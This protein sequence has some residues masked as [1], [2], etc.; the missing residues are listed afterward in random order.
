MQPPSW[1]PWPGSVKA[2]DILNDQGSDS[3]SSDD[4]LFA[5]ASN[6]AQPSDPIFPSSYLQPQN[7]R[8]QSLS[9]GPSSSGAVSSFHPGTSSFLSSSSSS[10]GDELFG[11]SSHTVSISRPSRPRTIQGTRSS[12]I[13]GHKLGEGAY[14]VVREGIDEQSLRIVAVKV[15]DLRRLR[16]LRGGIEA[17][18]REVAVQQRLKKHPNLVELID[19][20]RMPAKSRMYIILEMA[21]GGTVQQLADS[22]PDHCLPE[23]QV[24]NF[25]AQTLKGLQ[26]MHGKGVVHRDI[27]PSNLMLT[28]QG[29]LMISDFGVAE[30]LNEYNDDDN[31]TR[32]SGSPAFQAPEIAIGAPGYSGMK[33]DVW[34]L[35][36]TVYFL[37]T[38]TIPFEAD[39]LL[40]LFELIGKGEYKEPEGFS[41]ACMDC[42]SRMMTVDWGKRASVDELLKHPWI[43]KGTA[44]LSSQQREERGWVHIPKKD[45]GILQIVTDMYKEDEAIPPPDATSPASSAAPAT[46]AAQSTCTVQ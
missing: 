21:N 4:S 25:T 6:S 33:V 28:A 9:V 42:I 2:P 18:E 22:V 35:G 30:F 24:A 16:K 11:V 38:G 36:V 3:D 15:L 8:G 20:V 29:D 27:K 7:A 43:T 40:V 14:A 10:S 12:F 39:N 44:E 41:E 31:V 34:A 5:A 13:L 19:V 37:L 32:T 45:L 26:Y 17:I 1:S 23:S 46:S